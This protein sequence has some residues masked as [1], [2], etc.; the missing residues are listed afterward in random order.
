MEQLGSRVQELGLQQVGLISDHGMAAAGY[1]ERARAL[2]EDAG[3]RMQVYVGCVSD[4]TERDVAN[5][6]Q[7]FAEP[8]QGWVALGGGSVIDT[9]KA[10]NTLWTNGGKITDYRGKVS[11]QHRLL[12]LVAIPTT[13]GTGTEVQSYALI[14]D[15]TTHEK[16]ACGHVQATRPWRF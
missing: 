4:P 6:L 11:L 14:S 8:L 2:L 16:R 9:A 10:C 13:A 15:S 5:C 12:P 1:V 3:V 7:S